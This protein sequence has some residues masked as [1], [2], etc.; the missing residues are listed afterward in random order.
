[1]GS[2]AEEIL[3]AEID[4]QMARRKRIVKIPGKYEIGRVGDRRPEMYGSLCQ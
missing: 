3:Y 4:P 2:D 1:M